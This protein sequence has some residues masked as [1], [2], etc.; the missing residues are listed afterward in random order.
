MPRP[1]R[2]VRATTAT[3]R[4]A[5]AKP[6]MRDASQSDS[7]MVE[8]PPRSSPR[9]SVLGVSNA[10]NML[11]PTASSKSRKPMSTPTGTPVALTPSKDA[12]QAKRALSTALPS[13]IVGREVQ[14]RA[15]QAFCQ[16]MRR[17]KGSRS[18]YVSGAPGTGKTAC[19][20]YLLDREPS[21]VAGRILFVNCMSLKHPRDV[22]EKIA[23]QMKLKAGHQRDARPMIERELCQKRNYTLVL[24][25]ID[26]LESKGQDILYSLFEW[27]YLSV[28]KLVLIGIANALDMTDRILPRLK[29]HA[30]EMPV[31][32]SFPPYDADE[33][34]QILSDRLNQENANA[35]ACLIKPTALK[36]LAKKIAAVSGDVRKALDVCR[37]AIEV[38]EIQNRKRRLQNGP[39][40]EDQCIDVPCLVKIFNEVYSSRVTSSLQD[41]QSDLPLQHKIVMS[42]L[43]LLTRTAKEVNMGKLQETYTR[44]C[45]K[46]QVPHLDVSELFSMCQMLELRG[47]VGLK[48][49]KNTSTREAKIALRIDDN[50]VEQALQDKALLSAIINDSTLIR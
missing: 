38:T 19:V 15:I 28:S 22:Y 7:A 8:L 14:M 1:Q 9:K 25:E 42:A 12:G 18:L 50:E 30:A 37:R 48:R 33:I 49:T 36:F 29:T 40:A 44:I 13:A 27:P 39:P 35:D 23:E 31:Q 10:L 5:V 34:F 24:D 43:L 2:R 45:A 26:Q 20:Q 21:S 41:N 46:R 16:H 17:P 4:A 32:I 3:R 11:S 6:V 47:F